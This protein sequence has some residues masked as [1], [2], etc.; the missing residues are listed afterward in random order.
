MVND[1]MF[2]IMYL[3]FVSRKYLQHIVSLQDVKNKNYVL[4]NVN[5]HQRCLY[6]HTSL[7]K[8]IDTCTI[9]RLSASTEMSNM[10]HFTC[11]SILTNK[12]PE[13]CKTLQND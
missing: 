9:V 12:I 7:K 4:T 11:L 6:T 13:T 3:H 8:S 1:S 10:I 5:I 2:L